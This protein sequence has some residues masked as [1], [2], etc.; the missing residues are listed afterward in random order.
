VEVGVSHFNRLVNGQR[1]Q[2]VGQV[3]RTRHDGAALHAGSLGPPT[4]YVGV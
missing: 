3:F 2:G 4:V 1:A